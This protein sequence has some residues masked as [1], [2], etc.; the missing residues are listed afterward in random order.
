MASKVTT[1]TT[2]DT[3]TLEFLGLLFAFLSSLIFLILF[4]QEQ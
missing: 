4:L 1:T 3:T 2:N